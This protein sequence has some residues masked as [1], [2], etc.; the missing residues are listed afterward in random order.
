MEPILN[1]FKS[2]PLDFIQTVCLVIA[3]FAAIYIGIIQNAINKKLY[4]SQTAVSVGFEI[5]SDGSFWIKNAGQTNIRILQY[6]RGRWPKNGIDDDF[7][8]LGTTGYNP[9]E[10][11][12]LIVSP[13]VSQNLFDYKWHGDKPSISTSEE[14][15]FDYAFMVVLEDINGQLHS[16]R[17]IAIVTLDKNLEFKKAVPEIIEFKTID[18][19]GYGVN[20]HYHSSQSRRAGRA[21][22]SRQR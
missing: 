4:K 20:H 6:R 3:T 10:K 11:Y 14:K 2:H 5:K 18:Q 19:F 15:I 7:R 8:S 12:G 17:G 21:R 1:T 9:P 16:I 13:Q 22:A